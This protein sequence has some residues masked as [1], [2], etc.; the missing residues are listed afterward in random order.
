MLV[1]S[2]REFRAHQK[3]Y[4]DKIDEGLEVLIQRSGNKSYKITPVKENDTVVNKEEFYAKI[5][6]S[7]QQYTEG[8]YKTLETDMDVN[9]FLNDLCTE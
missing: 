2:S 8:K 9:Q 1:V 7:A 5:D 6:L 3:N 4:L